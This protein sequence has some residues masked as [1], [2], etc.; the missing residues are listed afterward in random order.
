MIKA[1][2]PSG[3]SEEESVEMQKPERSAF[4]ALDFL[5]WQEGGTLILTPKFQRRGIWKTPARSY[6]IDTI[7]RGMPVPPVFLRVRQS[8][9]RKKMVREVIDGQQRIAAV[10]D[11]INGKYALSSNLGGDYSG[12]YFDDLEE[13]NQDVIRQYSFICEVFAAI[14]DAEV[15]QIFARLNTYSVPLNAQELR[16]GNFFGPFKQSAYSLASQ[17][18][19]FW[20]QNRLFTEQGIARMKEVELVS[21]L[22][23]LQIDGLQDKK[24][25][26]NDFYEMYDEKFPGRRQI[27]ARLRSVIDA[28]NDA[29]ADLLVNSEFR[30]VPLFYSLF[31]AVFHRM[32]GLPNE[33]LRTKHSALS[34]SDEAGLREAVLKLSDQVSRAKQ[35]ESIPDA[36]ERFVAAC[37]QQTDN[38]RPRQTR[39][40]EIYK[41]AFM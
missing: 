24:K 37:L 23:I 29:L 12:K 18:L 40:N 13:S 35:E 9:D 28:I 31:S 39:L 11:Y 3:S 4:A 41:R 26:I 5:E 16:N 7:L 36:Y 19:E 30:R 22:M 17:H 6:L 14:E 34:R 15:L 38:L 10:T 25:S 32:Y 20:R 33:K 1:T 8:D 27:E 2:F 21:E